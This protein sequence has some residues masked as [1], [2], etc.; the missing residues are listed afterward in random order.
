MCIRDSNPSETLFI[1]DNPDNVRGAKEVGLHAVVHD[2]SLDITEKLQD[3]LYGVWYQSPV[4]N[5]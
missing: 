5:V 4:Y 3:Y 1:D 2:P